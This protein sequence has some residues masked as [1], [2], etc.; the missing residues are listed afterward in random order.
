MKSGERRE[1]TCLFIGLVQLEPALGGG[2]HQRPL[3]MLV[4][5]AWSPAPPALRPATSAQPA[6][7]PCELPDIGRA[8]GPLRPPAPAHWDRP[9][10][11][12]SAASSACLGGVLHAAS[13]AAN[14]SASERTSRNVWLKSFAEDYNSSGLSHRATVAQGTATSLVINRSLPGQSAAVATAPGMPF[15]VIGINHRTAPVDIREKV[16]FAGEDLPEAL[17]ELTTVPGVRE[18]SDRFHL[19]PHRTLLSDRR[20][21]PNRWFNGSRAGTTSRATISTSAGPCIAY[22]ARRR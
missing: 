7:M 5:D 19:Q 4:R 13:S 14:S 15:V 6:H 2:L 10:I 22:R 16:V 18:S 21:R 8:A 3:P 11:A 20:R 12:A 1:A 17:R 9:S